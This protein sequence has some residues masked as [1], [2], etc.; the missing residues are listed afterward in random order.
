M[1][2]KKREAG[3]EVAEFASVYGIATGLSYDDY[4]S[5]WLNLERIRARHCFDIAR[6]IRVG[7]EENLPDDWINAATS[8]S[9]EASAWRRYDLRRQLNRSQT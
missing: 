5:L 2:I 3:S 7:I 4:V 1:A 9:T 6:S 8:D